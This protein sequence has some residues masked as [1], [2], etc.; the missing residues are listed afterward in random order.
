LQ[1]R[2]S[3]NSGDK[4]LTQG[5]KLFNAMMGFKLGYSNEL[6]KLQNIKQKKKVKKITRSWSNP[7]QSNKEKTRRLQ[8][9]ERG[10]LSF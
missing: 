1:E 2:Q 6:F 4:M 5:Q 7:H 9:R 3:F 10:M 8:Q